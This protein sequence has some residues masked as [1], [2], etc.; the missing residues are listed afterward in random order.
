[1]FI[2]NSYFAPPYLVNAAWGSWG[3]ALGEAWL[4]SCSC[5]VIWPKI[6]DKLAGYGS[7]DDYDDSPKHKKVVSKFVLRLFYLSDLPFSFNSSCFIIPDNA[8]Y[9]SL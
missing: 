3:K 5:S 9:T 6:M 8:Y 2:F 4:E 7:D 1:M